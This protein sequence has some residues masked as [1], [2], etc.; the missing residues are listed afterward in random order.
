MGINM[1]CKERSIEV[2]NTVCE[3]VKRRSYS[4]EEEKVAE[5][6][7]AYMK[8]AGF[9][10]A[11]TDDYGNV[12]GAIHGKRQGKTILFDGHMDTVPVEDVSRWSHD[13]FDPVL[14]DGKLYG[15]G[16]SDMKGAIG[17][18]LAAGAFFAQDKK[19][20]FAG[21]IY[22]AGCVHEE[23]FEGL[24]ARSIDNIVK[25]DIVIIGEA[26]DLNVKISQ[27]G[28]AEVLVETFGV[29]AHSSNPEKGVNAVYSMLELIE[30][31][32]ETEPPTHPF[33]GK[34]IMELT[35]FISKPYPGKSV[36]PEYA[37]VTFDRRLLD[38]ETRED[39]L[40]PVEEIISKLSEKNDKFKARVSLTRGSEKCY[41]GK[42]IEGERFFPGWMLKDESVSDRI[43]FAL[44]DKGFSPVRTRYNFCT[45]GSH[46]A[47]EAGIVCIGYG[48]SKE[49]L[50]HVIDEYVEADQLTGAAEGYYTI[51][52]CLTEE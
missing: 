30:K 41:T 31:I 20:D 34:G 5:Y 26:S 49:E 44:T 14:K 6:M 43:I 45:N 51:M 16:T 46:Y 2:M 22:F 42:T 21:S 37:R 52:E 39:V 38:G 15:R 18:F 50:A 8:A 7:I 28:R 24:A 1:L 33:M 23:C 35:D 19:R 9:D 32:R 25:P 4:G 48:P 27:R 29:P 12:I 13:P 10:E 40:R 36:L 17:A 11:F 47:G 3:L